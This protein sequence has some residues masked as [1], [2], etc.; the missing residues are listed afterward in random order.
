MKR[1]E[2]L[3]FLGTGMLGG[4]AFLS[5]C[6]NLLDQNNPNTVTP[7][8][9]W[10]T[11]ADADASVTA[12]YQVFLG[13]NSGT[14]SNNWAASE[15]WYQRMVPALYRSDILGITHDVPTWWSLALFILTSTND[16]PGG[17]WNLNYRGIFRANQSIQY[18]PA[19]KMDANLKKRLI[20]EAKFLRAYFYY[21]LVTNFNKV[22]LITTVPESSDEYSVPGAE[23]SKSWAQIEKDLT[24][25]AAVLPAT[26]G[27]ADQG[28]VTKGAAL[29]FLGKSQLFQKKWKDAAAT[30]DQIIKSKTYDLMSN[31]WDVFLEANDFNQ[32]SL[33]EVNFAANTFKGWNV[34]NPRNYEEAPSEAG[35]WYECYPNEWLV[36]ELMKEKT[37][38]G[39]L[40]PRVYGT[41]IWPGSNLK[42]YG[43]T[44]EELFGAGATKTAWRKYN[45]SEQDSH[46]KVYSGKNTRVLRYADILL[47]QA[48]ALANQGNTSDAITEINKVRSRAQLS[49]LSSGMN[50]T[51]V[52]QEIEHQRI[53]ELT[54]EGGRWYD[55]L[56]WGGSIDGSMS[57]KQNLQAHGAI[58][59]D[60]FVKGKHEYLPI[61]QS[62]MQ[63]NTKI[64]Q[65]PGY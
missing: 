19:I 62:E 17:L 57:I 38:S 53:C 44:Y 34:N 58:G 22:P 28:R 65:N 31:Y 64:K 4:A 59:A 43:Q 63:T 7:T 49:P 41:I 23:P 3:G 5:G 42:Y 25:A 33:L 36:S 11:A 14:G 48:E 10:K 45:D 56:R 2:F 9:F 1:K 54:D 50:K 30:F 61:P 32:E 15:N 51:Q 37:T 12:V 46:L 6:S 27:A 35:G 52:L 21:S 20:G 18:I 47:M 13:Q 29:G 8:N 40:D 55:L 39:D 16:V 26:Y 24:D 60:N